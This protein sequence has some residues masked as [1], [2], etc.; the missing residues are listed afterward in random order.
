M[1]LGLLIIDEEHRFGVTHKSRIKEIKVDVDVLT[2]TATPIPRTLHTSM[3]GLRDLSLIKTA[4][5]DRLAIRTLIAR[6]SDQ[7]IREAIRAE[8]D[9]SGQVYYVHNRV[10]DIAKHAELIGRLVPSARIGTAHGQMNKVALEKVMLAFVKGELDVLVCTTIVESGLDVSR[11]NTMLINAAHELGLA[12]LYQLRGRVGRSSARASCFLL[13]PSTVGLSDEARR[14]V[15][16]IQKFVEPGSGFAVASYDMEL[17]GVGDLLGAEQSGNINAVGYDTYLDLL[18]EAVETLRDSETKAQKRIDPELK[19]SLETRLPPEWI[20]D[21]VLRLRLYRTLARSRTPTEVAEVFESAVDRYGKAPPQARRL[22]ELM[23]LKCQAADLG[24][25][26]MAFNPQTISF[27]LTEHGLLRPEFIGD[28]LNRPGNHF[29]F[30]P[31]YQLIR[32]VSS[33]E[34]TGELETLRETLQEV[35]NFVSN[36]RLES[37]NVPELES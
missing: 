8:L 12:Q 32:S 17:R 10:S 22:V 29:R 13:V 19:V 36:K 9:R 27:T 26:A 4:P 7:V 18:A 35:W 31:N 28:L 11:A 33:A 24:F 34:W 14:R 23:E 30:T 15:E 3:L 2:M 6:P 20:P 1:D 37:P 5:L 16:T 21:S 25:S